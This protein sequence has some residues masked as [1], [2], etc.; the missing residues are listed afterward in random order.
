[1]LTQSKQKPKKETPGASRGFR[2]GI[3]PV[4]KRSP[5]SESLLQRPAILAAV[6]VLFTVIIAL[7]LCGNGRGRSKS[8]RL[9]LAAGPLTLRVASHLVVNTDEEPTVATI[10]DPESLQATNPVFYKNAHAGDRLLVW[11]DQAVIYS[12]A[13]DRII[14][15]LPIGFTPLVGSTEPPE[16]E[17]AT[18]TT[19]IPQELAKIEVRN[20]TRRVGLAK[21]AATMLTSS[22]FEVLRARDAGKK[23]YPKTLIVDISKKDSNSQVIQD[24][25]IK[26]NAEISDLPASEVN[27]QGDIMIIIGEDYPG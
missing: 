2:Y 15:V 8:S 21:E 12:E 26:I 11:S 19:A 23:A 10:Q 14:A 22:G 24:L 7:A 6:A 18:S 27:V 25:L 5:Q 4:M 3:I 20:G 17:S 1:M 16:K 9:G 13:E